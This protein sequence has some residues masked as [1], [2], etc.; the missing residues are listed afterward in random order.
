MVTGDEPRIL[1]PV[2]DVPPLHDA[3]VVA[4]PNTPAPPLDTSRL[5]DAGCVVVERPV[6]VTVELLPPTSAPSP[7]YPL[8]GPEKVILVVATVPSF[9]G[10]FAFPTLVQYGR[11]LTVGIDDVP[12]CP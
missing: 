7:V 12:T 10:V 6:H 11:L 2:H 1:N 3:V 4:T 9:A 5:L 8:N